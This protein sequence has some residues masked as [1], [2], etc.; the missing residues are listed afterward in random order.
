[1]GRHSYSHLP[2]STLRSA[3]TVPC[4]WRLWGDI[5]LTSSPTEPYMAEEKHVA[6]PS[7]SRIRPPWTNAI[8]AKPIAWLSTPSFDMS[9]PLRQRTSIWG[10]LRN[11][12]SIT[13]GVPT[14]PAMKNSGYVWFESQLAHPKFWHDQS[15]C[16]PI[17]YVVVVWITTTVAVK[18]LAKLLGLSLVCNQPSW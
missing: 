4:T 12:Y 15:K 9:M 7:L 11:N 16:M 6:T 14:S 1:M 13:S 18:S 5:K 10:K 3:T 2:C 17:F 8:H